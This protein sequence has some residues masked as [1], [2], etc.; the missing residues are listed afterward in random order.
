MLNV[1][2]VCFLASYLLAF[3]LEW[4]RFVPRNTSGGWLTIIAG[5]AGFVAQT[6]YLLMRS[7]QT[8]LPPLLS[9]MQDWL[10]VLAWLMVLI[11][12]FVTLA[13]RE[14]ALGFIMWPLTIGLIVAAQF[15]TAGP[16][17]T[18]NVHRNWTMLHV[19]LLV[20]GIAGVTV[21]FVVSLLY[22]WQH[23][24]MKLRTSSTVGLGLPSL[25]RLARVNRWSL[26]VSIPLL[27][28]GM[29]TGVGLSLARNSQTQIRDVS[30]DPIV[31]ASGVCGLLMSAVFVWLLAGK[32]PAGRQV[33]LL[34]AWACGFLL[35]TT[36]GAQV[37]TQAI[38]SSS[39][40]G[41]HP[42]TPGTDGQETGP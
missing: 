20:F 19:A 24:R 1:S 38:S 30:Q 10:L 28:F 29:V 42:R 18:A 11:H 34:T 5:V 40:H 26:L 12:L 7:Q 25:E 27:T 17:P 15:V 13:D 32:R 36:V 39:V 33:A 22:L 41:P 14:L 31:L 16:G 37:L 2:V 9:S 21:G 35:L 23:R 3:G 6:L 8:L 4:T